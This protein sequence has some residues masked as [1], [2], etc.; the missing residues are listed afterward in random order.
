[1]SAGIFGPLP[2]IFSDEPGMDKQ[3]RRGSWR[4]RADMAYR[5]HCTAYEHLCRSGTFWPHRIGRYMADARG[6]NEGA[7][8][9]KRNLVHLGSPRLIGV[10]IP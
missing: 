10:P 8:H 6:A 2:I 4:E 5:L 7:A 1:M 9:R 3:E